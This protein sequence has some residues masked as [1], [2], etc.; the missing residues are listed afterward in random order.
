MRDKHDLA[1]PSVAPPGAVDIAAF[2][3]ER[4]RL[5]V[6]ERLLDPTVK[7][8]LDAGQRLLIE[9]VDA[10]MEYP[11]RFPSAD[12]VCH[13]AAGHP[14]FRPKAVSVYED[15]IL[16]FAAQSSIPIDSPERRAADE[17][18]TKT[19]PN[20]DRYRADLAVY[21][22][23]MPSRF[24]GEKVAERALAEMTS[25]P[26][27]VDAVLER[28]AAEDLKLFESALFRVQLVMQAMA[29][30]ERV[31]REAVDRMYTNIDRT[32]VAVY[33]GILDHYQLTL[34]PD[35]TVL[36]LAHMLTGAAEGA[37]LR[38][39]GRRDNTAITDAVRRRS[40]LGK[41]AL[42][43]F[44]ASICPRGDTRTLGGLLRDTV[45]ATG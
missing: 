42:C 2:V 32:W 23:S 12:L 41:T 22:L 7:A 33:Q 13:E 18:F 1:D 28:L 44:A 20:L 11:F 37:G 4:T 39:L 34:R 38:L 15:E 14:P 17:A 27:A 24:A 21:A 9:S 6:G 30:S 5:E 8:L 45:R 19:W 36:D 35:V 10:G 16:R 43:V 31:I 25:D 40:V 29:P 3:T 26:E